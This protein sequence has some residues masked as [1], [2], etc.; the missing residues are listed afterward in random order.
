[1]SEDLLRICIR[2]RGK[3]REQIQVLR[4]RLLIAC[5][6]RTG[7]QSTGNGHS[8]TGHGVFHLGLSGSGA[9]ICG[10]MHHR[11]HGLAAATPLGHEA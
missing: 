1:M 11:T 4:S 6:D 9:V 2:N 5:Y 3:K 7:V 8:A 10:Q